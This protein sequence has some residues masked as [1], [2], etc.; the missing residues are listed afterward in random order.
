[1]AYDELGPLQAKGREV[2][3]DVWVATAPLLPPGYRPRR[4]RTPLVGREAELE[5]L[6][7]TARLSLRHRRG[8][9]LVVVGE[10]GLGKQRLANELT[11]QLEVEDAVLVLAG[12]CVPYGEAN[13]FWPLAEAIRS[14]FGVARDEP[15]ASA[16]AKLRAAVG[17]VADNVPRLQPEVVVGGLLH[18][19]DYDG[20]LQL[21]EGARA[22]AETTQALLTFLEAVLVDQPV[23]LRLADLHWADE[24]VLD[25]VDELS[26]Q[27]QRLPLV[28]VA[29]S[30]TV[31]ASRWAPN[32]GRSNV[33][34]LHLD[35]LER[36]A[37]ARLLDTLG[38]N[39][40]DP[41]TQQALLDRA[42]GNPFYLEE[43]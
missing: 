42:G 23:V 18:L 12:R 4:R 22:R 7:T 40:L 2:P 36:S 35:P 20:P 28:V 43:L 37:A 27:L 1:V 5:L 15:R 26:D 32:P 39:D 11:D 33:V 21:L 13:P 6:L 17:T 8:Q 3:V 30:R 25:M 14:G 31:L 16:V 38:G 41:S 24:T 29:T 19:L 10:A 34:V 9:T